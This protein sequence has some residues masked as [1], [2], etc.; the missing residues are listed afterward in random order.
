MLNQEGIRCE[1]LDDTRIHPD[2]YP[3]A[4]LVGVARWGAGWGAPSGEHWL[5]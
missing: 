5:V 1:L 2:R 3:Y 4:K